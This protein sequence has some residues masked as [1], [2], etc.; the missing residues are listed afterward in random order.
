MLHWNVGD[1]IES[2]GIHWDSYTHLSSNC[3]LL[4]C[5]IIKT[6]AQG[7]SSSVSHFGTPPLITSMP[8]AGAQRSTSEDS[9]T[10]SRS[11]MSVRNINL[12]TACSFTDAYFFTCM[13]LDVVYRWSYICCASW[14]FS[15]LY[16]HTCYTV[17]AVEL[18]NGQIVSKSGGENEERWR[19]WTPRCVPSVPM[20]CSLSVYHMDSSYVNMSHP[21]MHVI[22]M[23][24]GISS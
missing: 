15:V 7:G 16:C 4:V 12:S 22:E 17:S 5:F 18:Q 20:S 24:V 2:G 8:H 9:L 13:K 23:P 6:Q 3:Y 19:P 10:V 21:C 14:C 11:V 1:L